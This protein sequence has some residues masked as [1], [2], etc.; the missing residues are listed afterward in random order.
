MADLE[1]NILEIRLSNTGRKIWDNNLELNQN[2]ENN[3]LY[4]Y[5]EAEYDFVEVFYTWPNGQTSYIHHMVPNGY[6]NDKAA[7]VFY[8][9]IPKH[10]TSFTIPNVN[11]HLKVSFVGY[12][13]D[14]LKRLM[15]IATN[16]TI[17]NVLRVDNSAVID[18]SYNGD[19]VPK[20][21]LKLGELTE[22]MA[23]L[24]PE[25]VAGQVTNLEKQVNSNYIELSGKIA[26]L[27]T[28]G[29]IYTKEEIDEKLSSLYTYR[30]VV[31]T[32]TELP[33]TNVKNGDAYTVLDEG[34]TY[35]W[36][37]T[38]WNPISNVSVD[39]SDYYSKPEINNMVSALESTLKTEIIAN[40]N[41]I[42]AL[43]NNLTAYKI[44]TN[45]ELTNIKAS[46]LNKVNASDVYTKA[47]VDVLAATAY[48][49]KGSVSTIAAL[50]INPVIGDV[51]NVVGENNANYA[52][53]G[54]SWDS[55]G[56]I[57]DLTGFATKDYVD[58]LLVGG[59]INLG[60]YYTKAEADEA[61]RAKYD[62]LNISIINL[63]G[64]VDAHDT[65]IATMQTSINSVISAFDKVY[66]KSEV[67]TKTETD[68]LINSAHESFATK[69]YVDANINANVNILTN[70]ITNEVS[71]INT[72]ITDTTS[73]LNTSIESALNSAKTYTDTHVASINTALD[74]IREELTTVYQYKGSVA[75][76][77]N[78]PTNA[79]LGDV[80]N[81]ES[82]GMNYA[83]AG[84]S[85]DNLGSI[86]NL[87]GYTT[88][89]EFGAYQLNVAANINSLNSKVSSNI[90]SIA[91]I[92]NSIAGISANIANINT[93][94]NNKANTSDVY[95]RSQINTTVDNLTTNI[96]KKANTA[97]VYSKTQSDE[98][99]LNVNGVANVAKGVQSVA[100]ATNGTL[101]TIKFTTDDKSS[102]VTYNL[103]TFM[104]KTEANNAIEAAI[105]S[106]VDSAPDELNTLKELATAVTDN[107]SIL[108]S[109]NESIT[110]K[111]NKD[112]VYTK[113]EIE[114]L[115]HI[116]YEDTISKAEGLVDYN[117]SSKVIKLATNT[118]ETEFII[119][120]G[121]IEGL[122]E[123]LAMV[124][125]NEYN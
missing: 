108:D 106:L 51:Y 78:L 62:P 70:R 91:S 54:T 44:S 50:P 81:V 121:N 9:D 84:S 69:D 97:D 13:T 14:A 100:T 26:V 10:I 22:D 61:I 118:T 89:D 39:M 95:T 105:A 123:L 88:K 58:S 4:L 56:P 43:N 27:P 96:N 113:E 5:C 8:D 29:N 107:K 21:W 79:E 7:F 82:T 16:N 45:N 114:D 115:G 75:S 72:S 94:L 25:N 34:T 37:G 109:L 52:W 112:D 98:R 85:W 11:A 101:N 53:N 35:V 71:K 68:N 31:N 74:E 28:Y 15:P 73:A 57:I 2:S 104:T 83:W 55:L 18:A 80:Y 124:V 63:T 116:T 59:S 47:E 65:T 23:N 122:Q 102:V 103:S 36:N 24:D 87:S 30:G 92:N 119:T 66:S 90:S 17:I 46:M 20:L 64:R 1:K 32:Y 120:E 40:D 76:I 67:Y 42:A 33:T 12:Q 41:D 48:K 77:E 111:A 99:F 38:T 19:D 86:I 60:N 6:N 110:T 117:D 49:Y 125:P 93:K 3:R